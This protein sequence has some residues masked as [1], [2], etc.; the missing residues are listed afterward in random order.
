MSKRVCFNDVVTVPDFNLDC[1]FWE[2]I[3]DKNSGEDADYYRLCWS[4]ADDTYDQIMMMD[5]WGYRH[6]YFDVPVLNDFYQYC[7]M[8]WTVFEVCR[9]IELAPKRSKTIKT[10]ILK[11]QPIC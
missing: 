11:R 4:L 3:H 7:L 1:T 9:Y 10:N 5:W 8:N 6:D 2:R